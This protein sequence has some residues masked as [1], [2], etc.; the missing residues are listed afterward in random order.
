MN[1]MQVSK[2]NIWIE[3]FGRGSVLCYFLCY[4]GI[5]NAQT[6]LSGEVMDTKEAALSGVRVMV[7]EGDKLLS[8]AFTKSSGYFEL[9]F[10]TVSDS[11]VVVISKLNYKPRELKV[12]NA[13]K[14]YVFIL[15]EGATPLAEVKIT[16]PPIR[17]LGDTL[18]YSI[19]AFS[20]AADRTLGEVLRRMPGL[21]IQSNGEIIY[22]GRAINSFY[23]EGLNLMEGNYALLHENLGLAGIE[24]VDILENHQP[25]RVLDSLK[26][27]E[28]AALNVRLKKKVVSSYALRYG[29]GV[30]PF[31]WDIELTPMYFG[32][33]LQTLFSLQSNNI[34]R[35]AHSSRNVFPEFD[36]KLT[37]PTLAVPPFDA[38]RW[39]DNSS[40][41][42]SVNVLKKGRRGMEAKVNLDLALQDFWQSG[43]FEQRFLGIDT[44]NIRESI[45]QNFG[46]N[47]LSLQALIT[48]NDA[49]KYFNNKT[50]IRKQWGHA[51]GDRSRVDATIDQSLE[52]ER[53][54]FSNHFQRIIPWNKGLFHVHSKISREE[55]TQAL[56]I[57][58]EGNSPVQNYNTGEWHLEHY[59]EVNKRIKRHNLALKIGNDFRDQQLMTVLSN[60]P[61]AA[62]NRHKWISSSTYIQ[63]S[64]SV[65]PQRP[66]GFFLVELPLAQQ[67]RQI[68]NSSIRKLTFEPKLHGRR[69]WGA[70]WQTT[71][72]LQYQNK[73]DDGDGVFINPVMLNYLQ[74]VRREPSLLDAN[75]YSATLGVNYSNTAKLM[76]GHLSYFRKYIVGNLL[77]EWRLEEGTIQEGGVL[78]ENSESNISSL[79]GRWNKYF[80]AWKLNLVLAGSYSNSEI[81]KRINGNQRMYSN[82]VWSQ[83]GELGYN[84]IKQ[85]EL[86]WGSR[87]NTFSNTFNQSK[88]VQHTF[89]GAYQMRSKWYY[90]VEF[91]WYQNRYQGITGRYP[92]ADILVRWT[93]KKK[94]HAVELHAQNVLNTRYFRNIY[95]SDYYTTSTNYSLRSPQVL[96]RGRFNL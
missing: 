83:A 2:K 70:H 91:T 62:Q 84:G 47:D 74:V 19:S 80:L 96:V 95:I 65:L 53:W 10:S 71:G 22:Q 3:C 43:Q 48:R 33:G 35:A 86:K 5:A 41:T 30:K 27:S 79:S 63:P 51:E 55:V 42:G 82:T 58:W 15:E 16:P 88:E 26:F 29:I 12:L 18:R 32:S 59:I 44:L 1:F 45:Q 72:V 11:V 76:N 50:N 93:P 61:D 39:L 6:K 37:V 40:H 14:S 77:Q 90:K 81:E 64:F 52:N 87:W 67:Y 20:T 25:I 21:E 60:H 46:L 68:A 66:I 54:I 38:S 75:Q 23:V 28:T 9:Q 92:F 85:V 73:L 56:D 24:G 94:T 8:Y 7:K 36:G 13:T 57:I 78:K 34:G 49:T 4:M 17:K 31:L 89:V 69:K